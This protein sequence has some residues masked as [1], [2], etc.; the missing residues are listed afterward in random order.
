MENQE[1]R[2]VIYSTDAT[3]PA[4]AIEFCRRDLEDIRQ[5]RLRFLAATEEQC[6]PLADEKLTGQA[7]EIAKAFPD[8]H[9]ARANMWR[10][11]LGSLSPEQ[12]GRLVFPEI[13]AEDRAH[14]MA[15]SA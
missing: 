6:P 8:E 9:H 2:E 14:T 5:F 3:P 15:V 1:A 13:A 11:A 7:L 10:N 12:E 4:W